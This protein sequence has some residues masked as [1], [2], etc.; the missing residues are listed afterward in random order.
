MATDFSYGGKQIVSGGPFKPGGKDMPND[1][2][3]R[4]ESYADIVNIPNPYVGLKITVKVDET[5]NNKM[6][7]YI[8]KSL[9]ANSFGAANS[10]VDEVVR[11]VDYLGVSGGSSG[12]GSGEG[13]TSEQAQQ[14]TTAYE[15]SQSKHVSMDEVNQAIANAQLSGGEVDLSTYATKTYTDNAISTA[16]DGHTFKFLTQAEYD[17]LETKD[18]LVEYHITDAT[19]S[20]ISGGTGISY[21]SVDVSTDTFVMYKSGFVLSSTSITIN[22]GSST[23]FTVKLEEAPSEDITVTLT[24][25]NENVTVSPSTLTFTS[26]NYN[27]AQTVTVNTAEALDYIDWSGNIIV[28]SAGYNNATFTVNCKNISV[29]YGNIVTSLSSL[30]IL[31][32]KSGTF[33]VKLGSQPTQSQTVSLSSNNTDVTLSPNTLTFTPSNYNTAQT[34]TVATAEDS[35]ETND[36]ATITLTSSNVSKVTVSVTVNDN[37]ITVYGEMSL[38]TASLTINEGSSGTFTVKLDQQ[39]TV[40]EVISIV[41]N[42]T[43]ITI[44]PTSLTFTPSNYNTPQTVT[45][46]VSEKSGIEDWT[47]A[48]TLTSDNISSK[49]INISVKNTTE[50]PLTGISIDAAAE[51]MEGES[52]T[53]TPVL[54]PSNA[55]LK[56]LTWTASNGNV[57]VKNGVITGITAGESI[58]TVASANDS[59]ITAS[60]AVT[61]TEA[62]VKQMMW[63]F[64]AQQQDNSQRTSM[65]RLSDLNGSD[66]VLPNR[67]YSAEGNKQAAY[68]IESHWTDGAYIINDDTASCSQAYLT[69]LSPLFDKDFTIQINYSLLDN[70]AGNMLWLGTYSNFSCCLSVR[71]NKVKLGDTNLNT[72]TL[73]TT[74]QIQLII[75]YEKST[76]SMKIW[77]NGTQEYNSTLP[78]TLDTLESFE[79]GAGRLNGN[80][81]LKLYSLRIYNYVISD[82]VA[83]ELYT[84]ESAIEG[85]S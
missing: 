42:D 28:S 37:D 84:T 33:T 48:L 15:H 58:V 61:I 6:T 31:E 2:R 3:T 66:I 10:L 8:V 17:D 64:D 55:T 9:K 77:V 71:G 50:I 63:H 51:V 74:E 22:E 75:T 40:T 11:Y 4:V 29:N 21:V 39:P 41:S 79:V 60:C 34:V 81:K 44:N 83:S 14:L 30:T 59:S 16:L 78:R 32:G 18:P 27:V 24:S 76:N 36:S 80:G 45:V 25:S 43:N 67:L 62:A 19:E 68:N 38:S 54:T 69:T 35:D 46:N 13:L 53:L 85:R 70:S 23:T 26:S 5:N 72:S 52:I 56:E 47:G 57:T 73:S 82:E 20:G 12:G 65:F 7:D 49:T 1:A